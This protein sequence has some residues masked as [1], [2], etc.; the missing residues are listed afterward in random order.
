M[1][2]PRHWPWAPTDPGVVDPVIKL[3]L[4][5]AIDGVT[6]TVG[7]VSW[8][9]SG[10]LDVA[11]AAKGSGTFAV[12]R[13]NR[14]YPRLGVRRRS[15]TPRRRADQDRFSRRYWI[16]CADAEVAVEHIN[17]EIKGA[18]LAEDLPEWMI[19][20]DQLYLVHRGAHTLTPRRARK[21]ARQVIHIADLIRIE[22]CHG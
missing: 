6:V 15:S 12:L 16:I 11:G 14:S 20:S 2:G 18:H 22:P 1:A 5:G 17:S 8:P 7:E 19:A 4:T 10:M 3:A 13:L 9:M 21:L